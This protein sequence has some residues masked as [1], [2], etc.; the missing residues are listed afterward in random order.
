MNSDM[1]SWSWKFRYEFM[2]MFWIHASVRSHDHEFMCYISMISWPIMINSDMYSFI[3]KISRN[4]IWNLRY[5]GSSCPLF[6]GL[7]MARAMPLPWPT[8]DNGPTWRKQHMPIRT[9]VH[10]LLDLKN[11]F[12][13]LSLDI[14]VDI[15]SLPLLRADCGGGRL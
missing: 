13:C 4:H 9:A 6:A 1:N 7:G 14:K 2:I 5:H 8:R 12:Q 3:W 15:S 10:Y 11:V